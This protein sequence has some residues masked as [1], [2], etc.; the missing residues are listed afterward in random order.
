MLIEQPYDNMKSRDTLIQGDC[1]TDGDGLVY[2]KC[3]CMNCVRLWDG[4]IQNV[5]QR[6]RHHPA[7]KVVL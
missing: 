1:F 4:T 7:A 5:P 2:I 6:V 3:D